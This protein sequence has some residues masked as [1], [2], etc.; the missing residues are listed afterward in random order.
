[1]IVGGMLYFHRIRKLSGFYQVD[2]NLCQN[3][4]QYMGSSTQSNTSIIRSG[5]AFSALGR[6]IGLALCH[7]QRYIVGHTI[8]ER[9]SGTNASKQVKNDPLEE[10]S[11]LL[12]KTARDRPSMGQERG[13]TER[14]VNQSVDRGA[15]PGCSTTINALD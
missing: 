8:E 14:L 6:D 4:I 2:E 15:H 7:T 12:A 9:V 5:I 10:D 13:G 11:T 3:P 1:M